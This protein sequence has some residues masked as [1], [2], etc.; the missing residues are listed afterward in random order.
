MKDTIYAAHLCN[1]AAVASRFDLD[2]GD[3]PFVHV[4]LESDGS[5]YLELA[6]WTDDGCRFGFAAAEGVCR[7]GQETI[8][9]PSFCSAK[10]LRERLAGISPLIEPHLAQI[11]DWRR[12]VAAPRDEPKVVEL[13]GRQSDVLRVLRDGLDLTGDRLAEAL[14]Y[15]GRVRVSRTQRLALRY[16]SNRVPGVSIRR[17]RREMPAYVAAA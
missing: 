15:G 12:H 7:G 17:G 1:W 9:G 16:L 2:R 11:A 5:R 8:T 14:R 4:V 3:P 10:R 6:I 13:V